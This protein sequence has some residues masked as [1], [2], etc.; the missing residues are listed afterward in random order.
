MSLNC[1]CS[2]TL[3]RNLNR[4]Q[5]L[6]AQINARNDEVRNAILSA[7][8]AAWLLQFTERLQSDTSTTVKSTLTAV[9]AAIDAL[10]EAERRVQLLKTDLATF[11]SQGL[12]ASKLDEIP[13]SLSQL[14]YP[15]ERWTTE[16]LAEVRLI[17]Q[18]QR[19][20]SATMLIARRKQADDLQH[21]IETSLNQ[22]HTDTQT[23]K[24]TAFQLKDRQS[25]ATSLADKLTSLF[26]SYP[27]PGDKSLSELVVTAE[28]IRQVAA[29]LQAA[30]NR[31]LQAKTS[32]SIASQRKEQL[33]TQLAELEPKIQ[34]FSNAKSALKL[35]DMSI[36]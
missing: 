7:N 21:T 4:T 2:Q 16:C 14:G 13:A 3:I 30:L 6:L 12:P 11:E 23:L 15:L 5:L 17:I 35:S 9:N 22:P 33:Q 28:S 31:E 32:L 24:S 1:E 34:R 26:D 8:A 18:E 36:H 10:A 19:I 29:D 27:W 20:N 25:S